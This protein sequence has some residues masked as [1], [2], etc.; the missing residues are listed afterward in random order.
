MSVNCNLD[1]YDPECKGICAFAETVID[2]CDICVHD[3]VN[4]I[5]VDGV[6]GVNARGLPAP[7]PEDSDL[8]D[9]ILEN[10]GVDVDI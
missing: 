5:C 7:V 3:S 2:L 4:P 1:P 9:S 6:G 8:V 10:L